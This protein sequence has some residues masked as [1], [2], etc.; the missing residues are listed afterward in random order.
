MMGPA[1]GAE[2]RLLHPSVPAAFFGFALLAQ[3]AFWVLLALAADQLPGFTGGIGPVLAAVHMLTVGVLVMTAAGA[4]LQ[5]LPV[6]TLQ[7][8]PPAWLGWAIF[9]PLAGGAVL[10]SAGFL[11]FDPHLLAAGTTLAATA[12]TLY[13]GTLVRL[14]ARAHRDSIRDAR[15]FLWLALAALGGFVLLAGGLAAA[16]LGALALPGGHATVAL[17]HL[18][19]AAYGFM[20]LLALGFSHI[21]VPM[22]ALAEPPDSRQ[23]LPALGLAAGAVAVALVGL[24]LGRDGLLF[25]AVALGLGA[26]GAHLRLMHGVLGRRMRRRLPHGF[27]L[28]RTAWVMLP[29]S[30]LAAGAAAAG[31]LPDAVAPLFPTLLLVGWLLSLTMGVLQQILPFLGSMHTMR[32]CARPAMVGQLTWEPAL[33]LHFGCHLGA[34]VL[35]VAGLVLD[36]PAVIVA[37]AAC[38]GLGAVTFAAFG[39]TV[40]ARTR[41]HL[42]GARR[43]A[44]AAFTP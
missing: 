15:R 36:L 1:P 18:I 21:L 41:R 34:L 28:I 3:V 26:A 25:A 23:S 5:I 19:L 32:A 29:L 30:L 35:V 39:V 20:S 13:A 7:T 10:L 2:Q 40:A 17:G 37:G 6:A 42:R 33:H 44:P 16:D 31:L 8:A 43:P 12:L 27:R 11:R 22:L 38:G 9:L 24:A 4:T 14:L